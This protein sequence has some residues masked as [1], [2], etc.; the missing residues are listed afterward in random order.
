MLYSLEQKLQQALH[1]KKPGLFTQM[2]MS[3]RPQIP[4]ISLPAAFIFR[5]FMAGKGRVRDAAVLILLFE[6]DGE[7]YFPLTLRHEYEGVHSGQVSL[8]GGRWETSD[9]DF[10]FTALRESRRK[11]ASG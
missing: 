10:Q 1:V 4:L 2:Q 5:T 6:K 3:P 9:A 8:P 11:S 7:V